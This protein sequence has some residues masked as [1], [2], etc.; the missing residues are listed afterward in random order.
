MRG[1]LRTIFCLRGGHRL[2]PDTPTSAVDG[3]ITETQATRLDQKSGATMPRY[4]SGGTRADTAGQSGQP[5]MKL[6]A[7]ELLHRR[8]R[9]L[10]EL[11]APRSATATIWL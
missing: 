4:D 7:L 2:S 8:M 6:T 5:T 11:I 9:G 10:K 1:A 3:R